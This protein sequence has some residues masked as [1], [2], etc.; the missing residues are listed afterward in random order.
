M[1][2]IIYQVLLLLMWYFL[3]VIMIRFRIFLALARKSKYHIKSSN[4]KYI[5][6]RIWLFKLILLQTIN[7]SCSKRQKY[8]LK[9]LK[10]ITNKFHFI[11]HKYSNQFKYGIAP[12]RQYLHAWWTSNH[13]IK[14]SIGIDWSESFNHGF[15]SIGLCQR[16]RCPF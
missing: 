15:L 16:C 8:V 3:N 11:K 14:F 12:Y 5:S 9:F 4:T 1:D 7:D 13:H 2:H 10:I 6:E